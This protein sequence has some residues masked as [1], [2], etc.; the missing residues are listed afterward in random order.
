[1][2]EATKEL[3]KER[4]YY[5]KVSFIAYQ[6]TAESIAELEIEASLQRFLEN[7][8]GLETN[9]NLTVYR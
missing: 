1:M 3:I 5:H 6:G 4:Y 9:S 7:A 8:N 2:Q